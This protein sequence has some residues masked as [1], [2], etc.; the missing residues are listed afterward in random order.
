MERLNEIMARTAQR[1]QRQRRPTEQ[2]PNRQMSTEPDAQPTY[3]G[4]GDRRG[5]PYSPRPGAEPQYPATSDYYQVDRAQADVVEEWE[6][7]ATTMRYGDWEN[8]EPE[9]QRYVPPRAE[10]PREVKR[11]H[12]TRVLP[13]LEQREV[14][15]YVPPR[16]EPAR[17]VKRPLP[18]RALPPLEQREVQR[19]VPPRAE[20]PHEVKRPL[21]ARALPPLSEA[22]PYLAQTPRDLQRPSSPLSSQQP[23][24]Q[25]VQHH[26]HTTQPL[27]PY[28][29]SHM[30]QDRPQNLQHT[31]KPTRQVVVHEQAIQSIPAPYRAPSAVCHICK[32]AGYLRIDVPFGHPNFGKPFACE[33]KDAE[34]KEKRRQQLRSMSN[35]D[36]FQDKSFKTFNP[37]VPGVQEAYQVAAEYAKSPGGWLLLIGPNGC[38]K[39]H[40]A[41]AIANQ[42]LHDG[43]LV[44]FAVVP[45]LLFDLRATFAPTATEAHDQLFNKMREAEMLVL[46]D[47]G[48]QRS[49]P[50]AT[51]TLFQLLNYRYNL[52]FP[53]VITSNLQG[54]QGIDDRIR[55]RLTDHSLV[56]IVKFER[57]QDY[58]PHSPR[59]S[60]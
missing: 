29:T 26:Q 9:V 52:G 18:T 31:A 59:R 7:D 47:L 13:P 20:P 15:R 57:A 49:S 21:P 24:T 32:G 12:P 51:E 41:A 45:D 27:N 33:C 55:S 53:T 16:A 2:P 22:R 58:R 17:E 19:Y 35:L 30:G 36:A 3:P 43:A 11:P 28:A 37:R 48:A 38:G 44:L 54:L 39:T 10:S 1:A 42:S 60:S 50:W 14:Q 46:D 25:Q 4:G 23:A 6:D 40:L 8:D 34:R 5:L 56:T